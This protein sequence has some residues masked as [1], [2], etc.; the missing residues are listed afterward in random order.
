MKSVFVLSY[1]WIDIPEGQ[2]VSDLFPNLESAEAERD[3]LVADEIGRK[4]FDPASLG[5]FEVTIDRYNL[6]MQCSVDR[7]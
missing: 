4:Q 5:K 6:D 2:V 7:V 3:R 1:R